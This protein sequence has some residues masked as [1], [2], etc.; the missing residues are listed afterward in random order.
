MTGI[1]SSPTTPRRYL[2]LWFPFLPAER[3]ARLRPEAGAAPDETPVALVE[4]ARGTRRVFAVDRRAAALGAAPGQ[5]LAEVQARIAP[6][7]VLTADREADAAFLTWL[8]GRCERFTPLV[9]L[10]PPDGLMLDITGCAHLFHGEAGLRAALHGRLGLSLRDSI[11]GTPDAARA[12]ARFGPS[13]LEAPRF[14]PAEDVAAL[15]VAALEAEPATTRALLRAGLKTIGDL[16]ARPAGALTARF[17]ADP[18]RRLARILGRED[19]RIVPHRLP[20][21]CTVERHFP[22][23]LVQAQAVE[24]V[25][26]EL[27]TAL[28]TLLAQRGAGGRGFEA[29][30]F[31]SDGQLRR[32]LVETGRPSRDAGAIL[33]LFALRIAALNEPIDAGFGIETVR[34]AATHTETLAPLQPELDGGSGEGTEVAELIDRLVA[35]LGRDRVLRFAARDSHIPERAARVVPAQLPSALAARAWTAPPGPPARPLRL[36]DPP[37][38]IETLAEVPDGT[39]LRFRWRRALHEVA[40]AEGPERI[41]PEWWRTAGEATRD[42]YRLEDR[43]GRRFWVFRDGLHGVDGAAPCWFLHG[44]FA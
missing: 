8:A 25:L 30:L 4:R 5:T 24:A 41:A 18:A 20:D 32:I 3:L 14:G 1:A 37:E 23:P 39:P 40:R 16:A 2:A 6:L 17:G 31:R 28:T 44:L 19:T 9:A 7:A 43:E 35:R 27:I 29:S 11:A 36:F 33:R 38:P 13:H 12:L 21:A 34:L 22:E 26:A 42:Y 15:P 10:A